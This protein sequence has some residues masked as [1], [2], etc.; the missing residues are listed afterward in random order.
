MNLVNLTILFIS[1]KP[2]HIISFLEIMSPTRNKLFKAIQL[3]NIDN[4]LA[5]KTSNLAIDFRVRKLPN[6][7]TTTKENKLYQTVNSY[8]LILPG[9]L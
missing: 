4:F 7:L 1:L 8:L 9:Q 3:S 5:L 2:V 6:L